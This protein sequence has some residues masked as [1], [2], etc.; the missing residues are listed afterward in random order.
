MTGQSPPKVLWVASLAM[1]VSTA[2]GYALGVLGPFI[3]ADLGISRTQF[4]ALSTALFLVGLVLSPTLGRS[5]DHLGTRRSAMCLFWAGVVG[6]IGAGLAPG[7]LWLMLAMIVTGIALGFANPVTNLVV[8]ECIPRARQ[9]IATGIKQAAVQL[10]A[11]A[12]GVGLPPLA[13]FGGWR[14][15]WQALTIAAAVGAFSTWRWLPRAQ[16][17]DRRQAIRMKLEASV[18]WLTAFAFAMG[19]GVS[20]A[21]TYLPLFATE[22][23]AFTPQAAGAVAATVGL[24][25]MCARLF[26]GWLGDRVMTTAVPLLIL[27]LIAAGAQAL[28]MASESFGIPLLWF[29]AAMLGASA[30][31]W[32]AIGMLAIV[33][34][35]PR[36]DQGR[37]SGIV[38]AGFYGGL[39]LAP[40]L[41]GA[42]IDATG[43]YV[44]AWG[45]LVVVYLLGATL[46][47]LW[48]RRHRLT[49]EVTV[50]RVPS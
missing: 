9:G 38:L 13:E 31:A 33:R 17:V 7:F 48:R 14:L 42:W 3:I 30:V 8:A 1:A 40:V 34:R 47:G 21:T 12:I 4:G 26:W 23:L 24:A 49:A 2:T 43:S 50:E 27:A 45:V 29:G 15:A 28:I 5:V 16:R 11:F 10:G 44:T 22:R 46:M 36:E 32:N 35:V 37:A 18:A 6:A 19:V 41:F 39:M 20:S 25:G